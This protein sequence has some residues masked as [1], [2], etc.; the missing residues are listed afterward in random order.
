MHVVAGLTLKSLNPRVWDPT[1]PYFLPG[2]QAVMIS[3]AD[4]DKMAAA[5]RKAMDVGLHSYLGVSDGVRI[6]LDNGA[7]YFLGRAGETPRKEYEEFVAH[8]QPDWWPIPQDF[9]PTANMPH[10]D[11]LRCFT[12]TMEIN[13]AYQYDGYTPRG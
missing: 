10:E 7:F 6:Y 4:F 11:Q 13:L 3:Y 1:S 5:R 2:V 9:I 8:A 12:Q